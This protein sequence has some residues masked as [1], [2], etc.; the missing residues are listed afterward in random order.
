[1][2]KLEDLKNVPVNIVAEILGVAPQ[3]IR[4]GLQ[5]QRLPYGT[6]VQTSSQWTYHVSYELLKKYI[7]EERIKAYEKI[8]S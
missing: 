1:M 5:E 6:A 4:L 2:E 3:F 7:G 8:K